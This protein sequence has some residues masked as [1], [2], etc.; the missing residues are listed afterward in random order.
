M[1]SSVL[2]MM[3]DQ[4][5][6][7]RDIPVVGS[8]LRMTAKRASECKA[9][10]PYALTD[11]LWHVVYWQELWLEELR[12]GKPPPMMQVWSGDWKETEEHQFGELREKFLEGL[13]EAR[14]FCK[15]ELSSEQAE[16]LLR[17]GI[18]AAYHIGQLNLIKRAS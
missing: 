10:M 6:D 13:Q 12:G 16:I 15:G 3:F 5:L 14:L 11:N 2:K 18:H 1:E 7:G 9:G 8:M 17:I 4:I